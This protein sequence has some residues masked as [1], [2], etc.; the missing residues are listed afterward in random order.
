MYTRHCYH[1]Y[2]S[3]VERIEI[4]I[5]FTVLFIFAMVGSRYK[6]S[7]DFETPIPHYIRGVG[8]KDFLPSSRH[9]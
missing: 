3:Q 9:M 4:S 5:R 6:T 2:V 8:R 1:G 7:C